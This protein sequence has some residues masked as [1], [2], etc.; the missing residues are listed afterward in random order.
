MIAALT[1]P[2]AYIPI[3]VLPAQRGIGA[4]NMVGR[5]GL[6]ADYLSER[7]AF[8]WIVSVVVRHAASFPSGTRLILHHHGEP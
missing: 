4:S 5:H 8:A 6:R 1:N 3:T 2:A 7:C